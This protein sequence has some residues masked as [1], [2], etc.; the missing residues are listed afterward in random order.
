MNWD[1]II[2][3]EHGHSILLSWV[4]N[5]NKKGSMLSIN[6]H[7][8]LVTDPLRTTGLWFHHYDSNMLDGYLK[9]WS[10]INLFFFSL[11]H[12]CKVFFFHSNEKSS[13]CIVWSQ[14]KVTLLLAIHWCGHLSLNLPTIH[15]FPFP[16]TACSSGLCCPI[17][18]LTTIQC[19]IPV[20]PLFGLISHQIFIYC[21]KKILSL[22][23]QFDL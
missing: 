23:F 9:L 4:S 18:L 1:G 6:F 7:L 17:V 14:H 21:S 5:C 8:L 16:L 15:Q 2:Y 19:N 10:K 12:F 13:Y 3:H 11:K 22:Y 20:L